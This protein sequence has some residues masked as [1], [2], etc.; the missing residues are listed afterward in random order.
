MLGWLVKHDYVIDV[1]ACCV[2]L[3]VRV[4]LNRL[5]TLFDNDIYSTAYYRGRKEDAESGEILEDED[6]YLFEMFQMAPLANLAFV[7]AG[8]KFPD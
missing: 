5:L 3:C 1:H 7:Q 2:C 4:T 8:V 6:G